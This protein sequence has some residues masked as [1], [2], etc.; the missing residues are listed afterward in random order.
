[1]GPSYPWQL[2]PS[3]MDKPT[4]H[5]VLRQ[6]HPRY[7]LWHAYAEAQ[8]LHLVHEVLVHLPIQRGT[9]IGR[10]DRDNVH[11]TNGIHLW[12]LNN[13]NEACFQIETS[14]D[15]I[16]PLYGVLM[17]A[18][19]QAKVWAALPLLEEGDHRLASGT[20]S[21]C[22]RFLLGYFMIAGPMLNFVWTAERED[23]ESLTLLWFRLGVSESMAIEHTKVRNPVGPFPS[24]DS[25]LYP[26]RAHI[27]TRNL[28]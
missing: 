3:V 17:H 25:A 19:E 16:D 5:S 1:M 28:A 14:I 2:S 27:E 18:C 23:A 9:I 24:H 15:L 10:D 21:E 4:L 22:A 11:M 6:Q 7:P 12:S 8:A 13:Y 20:P 26:F